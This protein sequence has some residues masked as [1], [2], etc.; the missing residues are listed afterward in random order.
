MKVSGADGVVEVEV[1]TSTGNAS[2]AMP[3]YKS[4]RSL[5]DLYGYASRQ[6]MERISETELETLAAGTVVDLGGIV[7]VVL[8]DTEAS[9]ELFEIIRDLIQDVLDPPASGVMFMKG[10]HMAPIV[11]V[12]DVDTIYHEGSCCSGTTAAVIARTYEKPDGSYEYEIVQPAGSLTG[13]A[14]SEGGVVKNVRIS[15]PVELGPVRTVTI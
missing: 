9:D 8:E 2:I 5:G 11:Y 7:H 12:K 3:A 14:S 6:I 13:S 1:D 10:S 4:A 15:G